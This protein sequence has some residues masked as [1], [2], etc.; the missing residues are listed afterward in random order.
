VELC[1]ALAWHS[2]L[3]AP[4]GAVCNCEWLCPLNQH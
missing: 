2:L 3:K 1:S 4:S